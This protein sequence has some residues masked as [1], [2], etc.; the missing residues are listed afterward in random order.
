MKKIHFLILAT[1]AACICLAQQVPLFP[2]TNL[3]I[4][5]T[6]RELGAS[7][8]PI[9]IKE[10][11]SGAL[12][13]YYSSYA[14]QYAG[15][16]FSS[17]SSGSRKSLSE[18]FELLPV[19]WT[20]N[21]IVELYGEKFLVTYIWEPSIEEIS[22]FAEGGAFKNIQLKLKLL[23]SN[24]IGTIEPFPGLTR[25][26]YLAKLDEF[27]KKSDTRKVASPAAQTQSISNLKQFSLGLI[28]YAT[29]YDDILPNVNS[30]KTIHTVT[31]P[32]IKNNTVFSTLNP[33]KPGPF[34]FNMCLGGVPF[35][36]IP[37]VAQTPML[38]DPTAWPTGNFLVGY[39]DGHVKMVGADVWKDLQ[40]YFKLKLKRVGKPI[41]P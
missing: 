30:V 36:S 32:Y 11:S 35:T 31:S 16:G 4:E 7:Y 37:E 1:T 38:F 25:D 28:M 5:K 15:L 12:G 10:Q 2:G 3:P 17:G 41:K 34:H 14:F 24:Q 22:A 18:I 21:Q 8:F 39:A 33:N 19:S 9:K 20:D 27:Q 26:N 23:K 40:K 29:D 6:P 13:D